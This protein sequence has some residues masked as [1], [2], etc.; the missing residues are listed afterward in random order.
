MVSFERYKR[1]IMMTYKGLIYATKCLRGPSERYLKS[2]QIEVKSNPVR[3]KILCLDLDETLIH[4]CT[5]RDRPDAVLLVRDDLGMMV[6]IPF[7]IRP[8]LNEFLK[9]MSALYSIV[10]FTAS[11]PYYA[12]AILNYIDPTNNFISDV[13]TRENCMETK[14]GLLVKDLR[15]ITNVKMKDVILVDNL[16]HS[17]GLQID[18]GIPILE[19]T[20]DKEDMELVYLADYLEEMALADD[21]R[22]FNKA[23]LRL[24]SL[25]ETREDAVSYTHLTLP[26]IYS[27]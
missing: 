8:Y 5:L 22:T 19:F 26:T 6:N 7:K 4:T 25:I 20:D 23:K 1:H 3:N 9:R 12:K 24:A 16:S 14:N 17:F 11:L 13:L 10:V 21:V 15:I 27:V 2:R 18:N